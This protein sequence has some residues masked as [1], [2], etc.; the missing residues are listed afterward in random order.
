MNARRI[1]LAVPVA[2]L[3]VAGC[4]RSADGDPSADRSPSTQGRGTPAEWRIAVAGG[5]GTVGP[6]TTRAELEGAFSGVLVDTMIHLGE[7]QFAPGTVVHPSDSL[8]AL[9]IVWQDT[10][11][12]RP[13]RVQVSGDSTR[14]VIGPGITL[15]TRLTE[16]QR[17]NE[18]PFSLTGFGWDYSGT[19]MGWGEGALEQALLGGNGRVIL[20]LHPDSSAAE[21]DVAEV[22]GDAVFESTHPAMQRLDPSVYQLIVEFDAPPDA[23]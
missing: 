8:R 17:L 22:S 18:R 19:I 7:G 15:G 4:G 1:R 21:A 20:R 6:T 2:M 3:V 10:A 23:P 12:T 11:R 16:L 13:W 14:W 5:A 9:E